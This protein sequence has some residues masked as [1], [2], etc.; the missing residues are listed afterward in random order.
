MRSDIGAHK[1]YQI[2]DEIEIQIPE[3]KQNVTKNRTK[4]SEI[5]KRAVNSE[6]QEDILS[7]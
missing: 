7:P 2:K 3:T 1:T 6:L 5:K 4:I